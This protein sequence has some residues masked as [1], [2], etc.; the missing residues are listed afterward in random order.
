MNYRTYSS[1]FA[2]NQEQEDSIGAPGNKWN[3]ESGHYFKPTSHGFNL[4]SKKRLRE[5]MAA[6]YIS[7]LQRK[8]LLKLFLYPNGLNTIFSSTSNGGFSAFWNWSLAPLA[9]HFNYL[10]SLFDANDQTNELDVERLNDHDASG[11]N[12]V[13]GIRRQFSA[14][15]S[16]V[17]NS[18][19]QQCAKLKNRFQNCAEGGRSFLSD[20]YY[21]A[22]PAPA[23]ALAASTPSYEGTVGKL[24]Y[25]N[26]AGNTLIRQQFSG[27]AEG[28]ESVAVRDAKGFTGQAEALGL[29]LAHDNF[30]PGRQFVLTA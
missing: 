24:T 5:D 19:Q 16:N 9:K 14:I 7:D 27:T 21:N 17:R 2:Q 25:S 8:S 26:A 4:R 22:A 18:I 28:Q 10:K 13:Y 29:N 12:A 30:D 1:P 3:I 6:S 11:Q 23:F 20:R 15:A